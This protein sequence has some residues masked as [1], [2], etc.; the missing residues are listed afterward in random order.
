LSNHLLFNQL[1]NKFLFIFLF[2]LSIFSF[3]CGSNE[4]T[5]QLSADERFT[6]GIIAYKDEDYLAA[7][8]EFKIVSLQYQGSKVADSAQFYMAECRYLREEYILAAFEYDVLIRNMYSSNFIP[9]A[10][11]KRATCFYDLSP[12]SYLD[13]NYSRKAIDEYQAFIEYHPT[14]TLV[15]LAEQ[16]ITEL[17][18]KLALKDY[19][20]GVTYMHMEY[21]RA[22]TYYFDVVLDKYHDTPYAEPALFK[23]AQALANR[24]KFTDAKETIEKFCVKYPSS[25]FIAEAQKLNSEIKARMIEE[26]EQKQKSLKQKKD[27]RKQT[28]QARG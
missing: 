11:F 23:K 18:T 16:R 4:A 2:I 1:K 27:E 3:D 26:Y 6:L 10:R 14:D 22:A 15:P 13:Q 21:Y 25:M 7:I 12:K 20:N 5:P 8:E 24:K 28:P 17:N 19:E 9:Q